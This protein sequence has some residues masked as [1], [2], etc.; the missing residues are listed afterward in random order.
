MRNLVRAGIT[1][2]LLF[3]NLAAPL[4]QLAPGPFEDF[5]HRADQGDADAQFFLGFSYDRH[6]QDYAAAVGWYRK[7]ADQGLAAAQ[8]KLGFMY[9]YGRGVPRDYAAAVGWYRKAADQGLAPAQVNLGIMYQYSL[10]VPQDNAVAVGWYRKAAD[11]GYP[12]A[13]NELGFMYENGRGVPQDFVSAHMW[14][15]LAAKGRNAFAT[16]NLDMVAAK[17]TPAQIGEAEKRFAEWRPLPAYSRDQSLPD[18][19]S[20]PIAPPKSAPPRQ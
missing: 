8:H 14:F 15:N 18:P 13:Q 12:D 5:R 3:L 4:A 1:V 19:R 17:M 6:D 7:A 10:G 20:A 16:K 2:A 11:R 9:Q